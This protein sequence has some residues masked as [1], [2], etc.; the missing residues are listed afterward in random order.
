MNANLF[1][2]LTIFIEHCDVR[3]PFGDIYAE[4][5]VLSLRGAGAGGGDTPV[6]AFP[7]AQYSRAFALEPVS[8]ARFCHAMAVSVSCASYPSL[9]LC[10]GS[11]ISIKSASVSCA[12]P[13]TTT[14]LLLLPSRLAASNRSH[15]RVTCCTN[16]ASTLWPRL[17]SMR[18]FGATLTAH[19]GRH[20]RMRRLPG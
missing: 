19:R 18:S 16:T 3:V 14:T 8:F 20:G 13:K 9:T 6:R 1:N 17:R 11:R 12:S 7:A 2:D 15:P 4:V 5:H 10:R